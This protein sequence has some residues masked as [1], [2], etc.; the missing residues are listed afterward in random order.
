MEGEGGGGGGG[1]GVTHQDTPNVME[2]EVPCEWGSHTKVVE[3]EVPCGG[4]APR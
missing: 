2:G 3:G 1:G 4:H